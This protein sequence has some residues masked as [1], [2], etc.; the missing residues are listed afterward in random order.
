MSR[1]VPA[2]FPSVLASAMSEA[3]ARG[4]ADFLVCL[5]ESGAIGVSKEHYAEVTENE[6]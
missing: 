5:S 4:G 6:A 3:I 2:H 1:A